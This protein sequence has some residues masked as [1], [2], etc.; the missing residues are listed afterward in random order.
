MNP[1]LF[2]V[3]A[4]AIWMLPN[5][6]RAAEPDPTLIQIEFPTKVGG[7]EK[8]KVHH[9]DKR[10]LGYQVKY[11]AQN[12]VDVLDVY[13][14][15]VDEQHIDLSHEALVAGYFSEARQGIDAAVSRGIYMSAQDY[16][17]VEYRAGDGKIRILRSKHTIVTA[18]GELLSH[19][20]VTEHH[21]VVIKVRVSVPSNAI[22]AVFEEFQD[23]VFSLI[24]I[25]LSAI[26]E[27]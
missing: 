10:A 6:I 9:Y 19:A 7:F 14:F 24:E 4:T 12:G 13:V 11:L 27:S 3:L 16:G 1:F 18:Q 22:A 5:S 8:A 26:P 15:P 17:A 23:A 2:V 21:G 25:G 20:Y